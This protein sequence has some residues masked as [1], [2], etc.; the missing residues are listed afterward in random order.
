[1]KKAYK[2]IMAVLIAVS[3]LT[4][5]SAAKTTGETKISVEVTPEVTTTTETTET[6]EPEETTAETKA[7]KKESHYEFK[8]H[9]SSDLFNEIMGEKKKEAYYN[10]VD[11]V[12]A[13]KKEFKCA[14]QETYDWMIF[15]YPY[16][17][18]PV[19]SDYLLPNGGSFDPATGTGTYAFKV[20]DEEFYQ[21]LDE[22]EVMVTGILNEALEDDYDD[23]EKALALYQY[24]T[25]HF[26]YDYEALDYSVEDITAYRAFNAGKGICQEISTVYSYLLMQAGVDAATVSGNR[27]YDGEGHQW[28]IVRVYGKYYQVDPTYGLGTT[29]L[30]YFLMTDDK[31]EE[32]DSY[33]KSEWVVA[34]NYAKYKPGMNEDDYVPPYLCSDDSYSELWGKYPLSFDTETKILNYE[35]YCTWEPG[36]FDYGKLSK[37]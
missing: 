21:K 15:Q 29:D 37:E 16:Y 28:S 1:M 36:T 30:T 23:F 27:E 14:D 19:L 31:R 11:A 9:V 3:I 12:L 8:T 17:C 24:V 25:T 6:T 2:N 32:E 13:H 35:D 34:N 7:P 10:L 18:F 33:T 26:E 4:G 20:S 22:F 5:C